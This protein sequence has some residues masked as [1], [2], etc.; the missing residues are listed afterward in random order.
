MIHSHTGLPELV[1]GLSSSLP[2]E[3]EGMGFDK[4]SQVGMEAGGAC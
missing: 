2:W 3:K 1:E 4:L